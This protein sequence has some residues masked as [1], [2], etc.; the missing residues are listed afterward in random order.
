MTQTPTPKDT[1]DAAARQAV[2]QVPYGTPRQ[3]GA[4]RLMQLT[5]EL[6]AHYADLP[7]APEATDA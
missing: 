1:R 3:L 2:E 6:Y 7:T 5:P 4:A